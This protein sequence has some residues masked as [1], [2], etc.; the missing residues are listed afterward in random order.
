MSTKSLVVRMPK[1]LATDE[2]ICDK[3]DCPSGPSKPLCASRP[4]SVSSCPERQATGAEIDELVQSQ[5]ADDLEQI[6]EGEVAGVGENPAGDDDVVLSVDV[7]VAV[8][9]QQIPEHHR[10]AAGDQFS[11]RL[12]VDPATLDVDVAAAR[13]QGSGGLDRHRATGV[14][15]D[16][17]RWNRA[18]L[19]R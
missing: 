14:D 8:G 12:Y 19:G 5:R 16:V 2:V 10:A 15:F 6:V 1:K 18:D 17:F 7:D 3:S 13:H 11:A 9:E 4:V